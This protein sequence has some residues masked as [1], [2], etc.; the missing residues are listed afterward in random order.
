MQLREHFLRV[1]Q[2]FRKRMEPTPVVVHVVVAVDAGMSV[3]GYAPP[4]AQPV[5]PRPFAGMH[6]YTTPLPQ[7]L[8]L[9]VLAASL[10]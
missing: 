7:A 3:D 2:A 10:V 4:W 5:A 9:C 6:N 1:I 8:P